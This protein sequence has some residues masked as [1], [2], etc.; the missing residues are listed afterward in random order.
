MRDSGTLW[1]YEVGTPYLSQG[2]WVDA[3][4]GEP[5]HIEISKFEWCT[6]QESN[7][8]PSDS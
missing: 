2:H 4:S 7:L 8:Q 3:A 1:F 6:Q 5:S